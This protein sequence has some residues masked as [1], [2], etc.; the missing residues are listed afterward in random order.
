MKKNV[1]AL[2]AAAGLTLTALAAG[3]AQ[4]MGSGNNYADF[5]V[6]VSYTV[7]Q[8]TY[9]NGLKQTAF[10]GDAGDAGCSAE[11]T[12]DA[13]YGSSKGRQFSITEGNPICQDIGQGLTVYTTKIKGATATVTAYCPPPGKGCSMKDVAKYGGHLAVIFPAGNSYL[14]HT[15]VWIETLKGNSIGGNELVKIAQRMYPVNQ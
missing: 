9:T 4:A 6:G 8:P 3:P 1:L 2:A 12:F 11:E 10:N 7:Y 5:Q 14:R 15:Q 13:I